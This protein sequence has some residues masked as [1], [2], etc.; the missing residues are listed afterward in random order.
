MLRIAGSGGRYFMYRFMAIYE[1][2][3]TRMPS[4]HA[5]AL[6]SHHNVQRIEHL[7][8]YLERP[9]VIK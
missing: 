7:G 3:P 1:S 9:M 6:Y 4:Q 8:R 2:P 5:E